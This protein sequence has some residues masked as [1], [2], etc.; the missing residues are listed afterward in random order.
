M[1]LGPMAL[2]KRWIFGLLTAVLLVFSAGG[3]SAFAQPFRADFDC[4]AQTSVDV[5]E[6]EALVAIYN[7]TGG[8]TWSNSTGWLENSDVCTWHGVGC[9]EGHVTALDLFNNNLSGN[10]P[11]DIGG[12]PNLKTLT[13][14]DNPLTGPVPVTITFLDLDLFHF[15]NTSLCEPVD[16]S[17]QDWFSQIVYRFSSGQYCATLVPTQTP[18]TAQTQTAAAEIGNLPWPQQTLTALAQ[19]GE[20]T[21]SPQ[22]ST[23][24]LEGVPTRVE[25]AYTPTPVIFGNADQVA[26]SFGG[27]VEGDTKTSQSSQSGGGGFFSNIPSTWLLLMVVPIALI[28]VGVYLELRDRRK[29]SQRDPGPSLSDRFDFSSSSKEEKKEEAEQEDDYGDFDMYDFGGN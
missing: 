12:F 27:M 22:F 25:D 13:L 2:K 18:N 19:S 23:A 6:C 5:D 15:Q 7:A 16:P 26:G 9:S 20:G 21:S 17:F 1:D 29:E 3:H 8:E 24:T 14:N 4:D 28:V 10:L 11:I